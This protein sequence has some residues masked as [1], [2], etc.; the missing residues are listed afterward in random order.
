MVLFRPDQNAARFK[1][2]AARMSMPSVPEDQFVEAV[3][4]TVE[5]NLDY[6]SGLQR[7][8]RFWDGEREG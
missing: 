5:N 1:A 3:R 6:V 7:G 4:A 8:G 2:G